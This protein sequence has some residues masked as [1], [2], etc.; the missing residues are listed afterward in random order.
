[1]FDHEVVPARSS[2]PSTPIQE[3]LLADPVVLWAQ[4]QVLHPAKLYSSVDKVVFDD[5][6]WLDQWYMV[7]DDGPTYDVLD[8]WKMGLTGKGIVVAVVDEGLEKNHQELKQNYD[9]TASFDFIENDSDP[10]SRDAAE[11]VSHGIS[12]AGIIAAVANNSFCGVGIAYSARIGGIRIIKDGKLTDAL[13]AKG[14]G[15]RQDYVDIYSSSWG[16]ADDGKMVGGSGVLTEEALKQGALQGRKGFGSVFVFAVGNGGYAGDCCSFNGLVNSIYTIAIT[17]VNKDGS[18]PRYAEPCPGIMAV[19]YSKEILFD[20]AKVITASHYGT[21]TESFSASSAAAAM[22]SGMIALT[23]QANKNLTWRDVQH[24]IIRSSRADPTILDANDRSTN[25][26][27]LTASNYVGFGLMDAHRLVSLSK[28]WTSV[29]SQIKCIV[30]HPQTNRDIPSSGALLVNTSLDDIRIPCP[31]KMINFLEH[32]QVRVNLTFTRRGDL[33]MN[34][35]SPQGTTSR[36]T[37]HRPRDNSPAATTLAN[38]TILTLH[39]WGENPSGVWT[40]TL[41]NSQLDYHNTGVLFNWE[42][43][44]YGTTADPLGFNR[45]VQSTFARTTATTARKKSTAEPKRRTAPVPISGIEIFLI[46][47]GVLI[48][49]II[50]AMLCW[51]LWKHLYKVPIQASPSLKQEIVPS[52]DIEVQVSA[53]V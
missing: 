39:H 51:C 49:L 6:K 53:L 7:R 10:S 29:P 42:L 18:V 13:Q 33:E 23:L 26:A 44:L 16:P 45:N 24:I 2:S 21:C 34:L 1:M 17:G 22:A 15:F 12:C 41:K 11:S 9:Q 52:E 47:M 25:A 40:L 32:V 46:V 28:N 27:N 3:G 19:T 31:G 30:S 8:V 36:L 50:V 38:W 48:F 37:H 5:P 20:D 35:T 43:V 14:L 4:Q